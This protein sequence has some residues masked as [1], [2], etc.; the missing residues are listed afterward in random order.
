MLP[1]TQVELELGARDCDLIHTFPHSRKRTKRPFTDPYSCGSRSADFKPFHTGKANWR[2]PEVCEKASA[3]LICWVPFSHTH[4]LKTQTLRYG[5]DNRVVCPVAVSG[6]SGGSDDFD[7]NDFARPEF[8]PQLTN[9][10][11]PAL[12]QPVELSVEAPDEAAGG[13][14]AREVRVLFATYVELKIGTVQCI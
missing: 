8:L 9:Q 1:A 2:G 14:I 5:S 3:A 11:G 12:T 13:T 7:H 6:P 4:Q 10:G